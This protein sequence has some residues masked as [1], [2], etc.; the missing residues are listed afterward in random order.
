MST[1]EKI[2][3]LGGGSWGSTLATQLAQNKHE[4]SIWEYDPQVAKYLAEKRTLTT[5]PQV[6][7]PKSV[8]VTNDIGEALKDR[9]LIVCVVPSHTVENTFG[10]P[11]ALKNLK[12]GALVINASKGFEPKTNKR[13][14]EIISKVFT[15][16]GDIV[17]LSGPSHAEEVASG[18]PVALVAGSTSLAASQKVSAIFSSDQFRVYTNQDPIGVELGGAL[19]NIYAV[20][21]GI[22]DG[23]NLGDNTRAALISRGL[24]EMTRIGKALGAKPLTFFGLSG[25][26]DLIVTCSS[27]HSRNRKLG[28]LIGHGKKLDQAL[29]EMTMVAEGVNATKSAHQLAQ[30]KKIEVPIIN[31]MAQVLFEN[32]SPQDSI[33]DLMARQAGE[34]MEGIAI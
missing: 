5:L 10:Q 21:C 31:E 34:E 22:T 23:L 2:A 7:L 12:K 24:L 6:H 33:K 28:T 20:A 14:S 26:G 3:V 8:H 25:L 30:S 17:I 27:Q 1:Q 19:K 9:D 18:Q 11:K 15:E 29:S 32:K 13:L 16:V 4:V